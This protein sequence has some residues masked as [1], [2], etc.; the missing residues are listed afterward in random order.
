MGKVEDEKEEGEMRRVEEKKD[1]KD[2]E[3]EEEEEREEVDEEKE[4]EEDE[5]E[6]G[7]EEEEY[8]EEDE[9]GE[10]NE[11]DEEEDAE[12]NEVTN[13]ATKIEEEATHLQI[14]EVEGRRR[15]K[16]SFGHYINA[17]LFSFFFFS[18]PCFNLFLRPFS[19]SNKARTTTTIYIAVAIGR[20][21][22]FHVKNIIK[23]KINKNKR[24]VLQY[25]QSF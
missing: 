18:L 8:D 23:I 4:E 12:E 19:S 13:N 6:E 9:K 3:D 10:E 14:K 21:S 2:E 11:D 25:L 22:D 24:N 15:Q 20:I 1:E 7:E 16:F 5:E 17:L